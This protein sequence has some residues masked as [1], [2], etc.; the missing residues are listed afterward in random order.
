MQHKLPEPNKEFIKSFLAAFDA[1]QD[2]SE[3]TIVDLIY[4]FRENS[5]LSQ[6]HA[7]VCVINSIYGTNIYATLKMA[8]H[9]HSLKI[10]HM[11]ETGDPSVVEKIANLEVTPGKIR[12]FYSFATKYSNWHQP[13]KFP[14]FDS[15][16]EKFLLQANKAY[17][18][19]PVHKRADLRAFPKYKYFIDNFIS[20]FGLQEF[21]Y[22]EIDMALWQYG[23]ELSVVAD[24][25]TA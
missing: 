20:Q 13:D 22:K 12:C 17:K 10:D 4:H 3:Q 7:K 9:I 15:I 14:I 11:L 16:V 5:N 25:K 24:E 6:I 2:A 18:F 19:S 21:N 1:E 23:K 8:K